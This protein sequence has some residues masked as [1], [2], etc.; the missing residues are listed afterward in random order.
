MTLVEDAAA[1]ARKDLVVELRSGRAMVGSITLAAIALVL[2]GLAVGPD[3]ARLRSLGP[4]LVWIVLLYAAIATA[5]RME[6]VDREDA[7]FEGFWLTVGD[8]RAIYLGRVISLT[9]VLATLQLSTW[10]AAVLLLDLPT[11]PATL[12][13]VPFSVLA[14]IAIAAVA[15]ST[16]ALVARVTT[17]PLLL[18]VLL[19][20]ML[21]PTLLAGVQAG[22]AILD[23]RPG[24]AAGWAAAV[25]VEVA[26]F[27]GVGLLTF[28]AAAAPA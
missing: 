19:L 14:A 18:P 5:D 10:L 3:P 15:A 8:R 7:A 22:A 23:G 24:D 27:L 11:E 4:A 13:L 2:V 17:Q 6:Q 9:V 26:L 1:L 25:A 12:L 21:V 20:P 28:E 16:L